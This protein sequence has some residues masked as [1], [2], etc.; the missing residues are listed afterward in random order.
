MTRRGMAW[1]LAFLVCA[2]CACAWPD[3]SLWP[4]ADWTVM[5]YLDGQGTLE[6]SSLANVEQMMKVGSTGRV[7]MVALVDRP[8]RPAPGSE[9]GGE[10]PAVPH[11][12]GARLARVE[13]GKFDAVAD[14]GK[15]DMADPATLERLVREA[16]A[17]WPAKRYVLILGDHGMGWAGVCLDRD[18]KDRLTLPK[19]AGALERCRDVLGSKLAIVGM[20]ACLMATAEVAAELAPFAHLLVASEEAAPTD[21]WRYDRLLSELVAHPEVT[22]EE[23]ARAIVDQYH[24]Q[25]TNTP[26]DSQLREA[27]GV[28]MSV[29]RLDRAGDVARALDALAGAALAELERPGG[30]D[31]LARARAQSPAFG[32]SDRSDAGEEMFDLCDLVEQ[33]RQGP[34]RERPEFR[35]ALDA[36]DAAVRAAVLYNRS[37]RARSDARGL[38]LFWPSADADLDEETAHYMELALA[39]GGRWGKFLAAY[40][41]K[42]DARTPRVLVADV[43]VSGDAASRRAPV[44][45]TARLASGAPDAAFVGLFDASG[46]L[47]ATRPSGLTT[48]EPLDEKFDGRW[49]HVTDGG[50]GF[51][52]DVDELDDLDGGEKEFV[53]HLPAQ[54]KHADDVAWQDVV[55]HFYLDQ[56]PEDPVGELAYVASQ[57]PGAPELI[58][59]R[60]GDRLRPLFWTL[61][62]SGRLKPKEPTEG[63]YEL[64]IR[65]P[66]RLGL[67]QRKLPPASYG[68]GVLTRD[69]QA[70]WTAERRAVRVR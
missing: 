67:Q 31:A 55:L 65:D 21:G 28:T 56:Q 15:T 60:R 52:A 20:D 47:L 41:A 50:A 59:L 44:T 1:V 18:G 17:R 25:F 9:D 58:H 51:P 39:R 42:A 2:S 6:A 34:A 29:V 46:T 13:K 24:A 61:T 8:E 22:D 11:W 53:V 26:D 7:Q 33:L 37:G 54:L 36:A 32:A 16:T 45:L 19:L 62:P 40:G 14:W 35:Q 63:T 69:A 5:V 48:A 66:R 68:L 43:A 49:L 23:L 27:L 10:P 64:E 3:R 30:F 57:R 38:A 70:R 4:L 12:A